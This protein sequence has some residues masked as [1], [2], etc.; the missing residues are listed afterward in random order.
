MIARVAAWPIWKAI[1]VVLSAI[2]FG[3][4]AGAVA[5]RNEKATQLERR[6]EDSAVAGASRSLARAA[7]DAERADA[8]RRQAI[9]AA[10]RAALNLDNIG[11]TDESLADLVAGWN[12]RR[13]FNHRPH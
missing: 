2:M 8:H 1:G 5:R 11:A 4:A 13:L 3:L 10:E 9:K 6:A 12:R 7:K